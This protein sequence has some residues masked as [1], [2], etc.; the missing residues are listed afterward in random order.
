[1]AAHPLST[2]PD[3][4]S[5]KKKMPDQEALEDVRCIAAEVLADLLEGVLLKG[6]SKKTARRTGKREPTL[7]ELDNSERQ[8]KKLRARR[9]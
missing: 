6:D 2:L 7:E 3:S 8:R 9:D 5:P 4:S 1:M